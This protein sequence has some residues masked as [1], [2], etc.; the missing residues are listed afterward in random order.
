[1]WLKKINFKDWSIKSKLFTIFAGTATI[2]LLL[3]FSIEAMKDV[4]LYNNYIQEDIIFLSQLVSSHS[5]ASLI[6]DDIKTANETLNSLKINS[7]IAIACLFKKDGTL[8]S[9]YSR[10]SSYTP[11]HFSK[12]NKNDSVQITKH[13]YQ[14]TTPVKIGNEIFGYFFIKTD[15]NRFYSGIEL[16]IKIS[17]IIICCTFILTLLLSSYLQKYISKPILHLVETVISISQKKDYSIRAKKY[18]NDEMGNLIESFNF[19]LFEIQSRDEALEAHGADLEKEVE[20]RTQEL[21][22]SNEELLKSKEKAEI[23][24]QSKSEFLASMSHEIRTPM[25]A[26]LGF[27]DLL[28]ETVNDPE[29]KQYLDTVYSNGNTLLSLINDVLDLS[30]IEAGKIEIQKNEVDLKSL[31]KELEQI[32]SIQ[33][34]KK[35]IEF[36]I[37]FDNNFKRY[38]IIDEIRLKQVLINLIGNAMKFTEQGS[39]Q[40]NIDT[41]QKDEINK[42]IDITFAVHD[43]G[44]GIK[45][46]RIN[47]IFEP[48][49]QGG[50]SIFVKYGGTG[51]GLTISNRLVRLMGGEDID[52]NSE[53][54]KGS[55]FY[56]TFKNIS[57][58]DSI[59]SEKNSDFNFK[60]IIFEKANLLIIDNN[61]ESR[62]LIKGYLKKFNLHIIEA[63]EGL[64]A[65]DIAKLYIPDI[66]ITDIQMPVMDGL[67]FTRKIKSN[68]ILKKIPVLVMTATAIKESQNEIIESG[69]DALI[70]KPFNQRQLIKTIMQFLPY[71]TSD[72]EKKDLVQIQDNEKLSTNNLD[73]DS[74]QFQNY[75][76]IKKLLNLIEKEFHPELK[77]V[78][79]RF[80]FDEIEAF[81]FKIKSV[82]ISYNSKELHQWASTLYDQAC[83]FNMEEIPKTLD[84]FNDVLQNIKIK[85]E[86]TE[87]N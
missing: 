82:A 12:I 37:N 73:K 31:T 81:A 5:Q 10:N 86:K 18:S 63:S 49:E 20:K 34:I 13:C 75:Q 76:K 85:I 27:T 1:M 72:Q 78:T 57:Y 4:Y 22:I 6:F 79:E 28:K 74:D 46:E 21:K 9:Y 41:K 68:E 39:V 26:I 35:G 11:P 59:N 83:Q 61:S 67:E 23:A 56:I 66:I 44:I 24:N 25:N 16:T 50:N 60:D 30:K 64:Q 15:K 45:N 69:C 38:I 52:V 54:G 87:N 2:S 3:A 70:T 19:M 17:A 48:F 36:K 77:K 40:L 53:Q 29:Q 32:F 7:S 65:I 84:Q 33:C 51:L 42:I 80:Y 14:L 47:K 43:T 62:D 58:R 8:F 55:S 71:S